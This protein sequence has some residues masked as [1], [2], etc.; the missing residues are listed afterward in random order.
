MG[1]TKVVLFSGGSGTA[2][3]ADALLSYGVDLTIVVNCYDDGLSTG[4]LR[5]AIPGMLGPSDIRK[6]VARFAFDSELGALLEERLSAWILTP[7]FGNPVLGE[8]FRYA[9]IYLTDKH[10]RLEAP[11]G[12]L[13]FAG[14]YLTDGK[15][16][17]NLAVDMFQEGC[18]CECRILNVTRG[19]NL[20]LRACV[21]ESFG[22]LKWY[23]EA[24]ISTVGVSHPIAMLE[25][26]GS[27]TP[28][29]NPVVAEALN[30]AD[31]IVYGPGT[32][33]SSLF[34][35]YLT[36]GLAEIITSLI[37]PKVYVANLVRDKDIAPRETFE[38]VARKMMVCMSRY[39]Q[40]P[41]TWAQIV[42]HTFIDKSSWA[43]ESWVPFLGTI[44]LGRFGSAG[45][46]HLGAFVA[47]RIMNLMSSSSKSV[48]TRPEAF[49]QRQSAS[50]SGI[51]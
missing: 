11:A 1:K 47:Q 24:E 6:N 28:E 12:N 25:F 14:C 8:W 49:K 51:V 32:Q 34:P 40:Y 38:N 20:Q 44:Y 7:E 33:H 9:A 35:S 45:N 46:K 29:L 39:G 48:K 15:Q 4:E 50:A 37:I 10:M 19:E 22:Q 41:V 36:N 26:V 2:S 21:P 16:D 43:A 27:E 17:F 42:T 18:A 13:V 5:K 30:R 3:I 23:S 31:L